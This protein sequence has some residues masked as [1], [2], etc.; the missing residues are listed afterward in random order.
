MYFLGFSRYSNCS[1]AASQQTFDNSGGQRGGVV[2]N[3][4]IFVPLNALLLV[5]V[6]VGEARNLARL[7]AKEAVQRGTDLVGSSGVDGM[8]LVAAGLEEL[9]ALGGVSWEEKKRLLALQV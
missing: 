6:R 2:T 9:G 1:T 5:G 3:Q 4:G 8:A 7:A